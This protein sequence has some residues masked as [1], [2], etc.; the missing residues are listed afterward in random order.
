MAGDILRGL[1]ARA[2]YLNDP[3]P[4]HFADVHNMVHPPGVR[5]GIRFRSSSST[6]D[7]PTAAN[8]N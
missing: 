7:R 5:G 3:A 6:Q 2:V 1:A 4:D 8:S